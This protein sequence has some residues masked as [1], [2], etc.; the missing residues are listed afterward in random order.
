VHLQGADGGG[1]NRNVGLEAAEAALDVPEL[2]EADVGAEPGLGDVVVEQLQAD[3]VGDDGALAHG[4]VG[5]RSGVHQAGVVLGGA[6]HGRVDGVAHEG[7]HGVAHFQIAGGDRF[8]GFV[9]GQGDVV[10]AL[11]Q[12]GQIADHRQDGHTLGTHRDA[13]LGLHGEA[14]KATADADD[15][16]AQGLG[17]EVD[18]PAHLHAG[19]ID[20]QAPHAGQAGQLLVIVVALVLHAARSGHH[21]QVVGVHD[22]VDVAGE[23]RENSV[24]G[25]TA[26][27]RRR[28]RCP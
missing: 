12:I 25:I 21:G 18:D 20:V 17:A 23:P 4:D 10:E 14:V 11:F 13:E 5:E 19:G 24:M 9:E 26:S 22:V 27:C 2:F 7:R 8:A 6:H 16:V 15:D 28:P 1:Q 3:A